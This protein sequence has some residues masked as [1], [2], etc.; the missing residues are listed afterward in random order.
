MYIDVKYFL[1]PIIMKKK[2]GRPKLP[3][4][5]AKSFQIGVRFNRDE[6]GKIKTAISKTGLGNADWARNTLLSA[7]QIE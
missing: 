3:K 7:T 1:I 5:A 4:G 2:I 6:A